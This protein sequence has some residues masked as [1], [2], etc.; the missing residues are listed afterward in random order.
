MNPQE[1]W[2]CRATNKPEF[3]RKTGASQNKWDGGTGTLAKQEDD[4]VSMQASEKC[5]ATVFIELPKAQCV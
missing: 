5:S 4:R 2:G 1:T 3:Q